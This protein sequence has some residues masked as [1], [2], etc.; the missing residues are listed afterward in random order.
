M[1][2]TI[3]FS[4]MVDA[5]QDSAVPE[6]ATI[7]N[8]Y[9]RGEGLQYRK[10][11]SFL[12]DQVRLADEAFLLASECSQQPTDQHHQVIN[13]SDWIHIQLLLS[14]SARET[15]SD[16]DVVDA[17]TNSCIIMR[18]P[19]GSLIHRTVDAATRW[20]FACLLLTPRALRRLL[21]ASPQ[22]LPEC[23]TWMA[24]DSPSELRTRHLRL[25]SAMI[26]LVR[27]ILSCSICGCARRAYMRAKSI[28]ILATILH[29]C[30]RPATSEV[31]RPSVNLS[32][33]DLESLAHARSILDRNLEGSAVLTLSS[34][35]K[36]VGVNRTK[37]ALGFREVYGLPV[38]AYWRDARLEWA[39]QLLQ[40]NSTRVTDVAYRVGYAEISSFTRAFVRRFGV[41]PGTCRSGARGK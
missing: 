6:G 40:E 39:R 17:P 2:S 14:G 1:L 20:Q 7:T 35:A 11:H 10:D 29:T 21:D 13:G 26:V 41:P 25:S 33:A 34:L 28:E 23:A 16:T 30:E 5:P 12:H 22:A 18:Y 4:R 27:E 38:R 31:R 19:R 8:A 9:R 32:K 3:D 36:R 24:T 37:L 15:I